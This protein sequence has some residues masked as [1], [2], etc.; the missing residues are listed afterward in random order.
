MHRSNLLSALA[1]TLLSASAL[2]AAEKP[3]MFRGNPEHTGVY[4]SP[5][6]PQP[7]KL[8][9]QFHTDGQVV[10]SPAV[11]SDMVYVGSTDHFLYA[12]DRASGSQKWKFKSGGRIPSSPAVDAGA[13]YF[14]S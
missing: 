12:I 9:W 1:L 3:A 10:S 14:G 4:D 7:I 11:T 6:V 8:K 2:S 13:V 5:G